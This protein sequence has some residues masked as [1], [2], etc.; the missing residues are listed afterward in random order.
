MELL[1]QRMDTFDSAQ[2]NS[3]VYDLYYTNGGNVD[4]KALENILYIEALHDELEL[5]NDREEDCDEV[6]DDDDDSNDESNW[7]NDYPDEDPRFFENENA[8]YTYGEGRYCF[9]QKSLQAQFIF[10]HPEIVKDYSFFIK[11]K[12]IWLIKFI[13]S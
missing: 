4:F 7:R 3:Y 1:S 9:L 8:E 2:I 10:S 6:Y 13:F 5:H 12:S 11:K